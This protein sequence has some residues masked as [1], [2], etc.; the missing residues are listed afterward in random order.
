M[1]ALAVDE[2]VDGYMEFADTIGPT[3]KMKDE[4][5]KSA[6]RKVIV[7]EKVPKFFGGLETLV[8]KEAE[9]FS[10]GSSL[11]IADIFMYRFIPSHSL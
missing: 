6:A 5:E 3:I 2:I 7:D 1:V 4:V 11:T 10:V 9:G 8:C